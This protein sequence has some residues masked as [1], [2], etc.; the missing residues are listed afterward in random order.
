M[1][2]S[3]QINQGGLAFPEL[4]NVAY[5]SDWQFENGMSLRDYHAAHCPISMSEAYGI[6]SGQRP[7]NDP[8]NIGYRDSLM[9]MGL[10]SGSERAGFFEWW[11]LMR[12][13]YADAMISAGRE[14]TD[15]S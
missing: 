8:G 12:F 6:W 10:R 5:N 11:A 1:T 14:T 2:E 9:S 7:S 15:G 4:G 13:E 3:R